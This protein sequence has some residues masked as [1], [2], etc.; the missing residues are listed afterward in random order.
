M[1]AMPPLPTIASPRKCGDCPSSIWRRGWGWARNAP[2]KKKARRSGGL[3]WSLA[4]FG[5]AR[6]GRGRRYVLGLGGLVDLG[7]GLAAFDGGGGHFGQFGHGELS[8]GE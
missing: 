6:L 1:A 3:F 5:H 8:G 7:Q 4:A 2:P